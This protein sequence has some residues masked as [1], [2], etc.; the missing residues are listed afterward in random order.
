M[1]PGTEFR[2]LANR[3]IISLVL[4]LVC[5]GLMA[6]YSASA[7]EALQ[8]F[9]DS[10]TFLRRQAIACVIGLF[11]M[12]TLSRV[13]YRRLRKWS[14]PL[15]LVS[16][17]LVVMTMIP[18]LSITT[19]GSSRWLA[20]GPLQFQPSELAKVSLIILMASGL[21]KYFW[22]HRQVLSRIVVTMVIAGIVVKQPDLG[23][24]LMINNVFLARNRP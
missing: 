24:A 14:W 11:V 15:A 17:V 12:F 20:V 18:H 19:M 4:S 1:A 8:S 5:F 7:P 2:G 23:T 13:D 10:T 16:L 9:Q 21:S 6:V 3:A 22:W